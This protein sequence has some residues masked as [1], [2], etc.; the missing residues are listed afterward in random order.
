MGL[1]RAYFRAAAARYPGNPEWADDGQGPYPDEMPPPAVDLNDVH[2]NDGGTTGWCDECG[3]TFPI[4]E[5]DRE[6]FCVTCAEARAWLPEHDPCVACG[7][8]GNQPGGICSNHDLDPVWGDDRHLATAG[9]VRT[10][11][12]AYTHNPH[13]QTGPTT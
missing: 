13:V 7:L 9:H 3:R 4:A 12:A 8:P 5:L 10:Y 6:W 11:D 1:D 2:V